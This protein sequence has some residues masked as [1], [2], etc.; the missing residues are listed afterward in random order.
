MSSGKRENDLLDDDKDFDENSEEVKRRKRVFEIYSTKGDLQVI[1]NDLIKLIVTNDV[2]VLLRLGQTNKF[3]RDF[4]RMDEVWQTIFK[5]DFP[6]DYAFCNGQLPFY[7][8]TEKNHPFYPHM[9]SSLQINP[10]DQ[11]GWKRFYFHTRR[12][13]HDSFQAVNGTAML[14]SFQEQ[15]RRMMIILNSP[16]GTAQIVWR[17]FLIIAMQGSRHRNDLLRIPPTARIRIYEIITYMARAGRFE[18][19][20]AYLAAIPSIQESMNIPVFEMRDIFMISS[21]DQAP[22]QIPAMDQNE[23]KKDTLFLAE[24]RDD[25]QRWCDARLKVYPEKVYD[26]MRTF[27]LLAKTYNHRCITS[28]NYY[29]YDAR[30]DASS[31]SLAMPY[32]AMESALIKERIGH[33]IQ[34]FPV[35]SF[36][37]LHSKTQHIWHPLYE[38][39]PKPPN[40]DNAYAMY[41][42]VTNLY[43]IAEHLSA[44]RGHMSGKI[45]AIESCVSCGVATSNLYCCEKC[46]DPKQAWCG[47]ECAIGHQCVAEEDCWTISN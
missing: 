25:F 2:F 15:Y 33:Y 11:S 35:F 32:M 31:R 41:M 16:S 18:W 8:V 13:Y 12:N 10:L 27:D 26:C 43:V 29:H 23:Y 7:V 9:G 28:M 22:S 5:K 1:F 44:P 47:E 39:V 24:H 21:N 45:F 3:F 37:A 38:L 36:M 19:L 42:P 6:V 46:R 14:Y 34:S 20:R 30:T 4:M 40:I 17:F